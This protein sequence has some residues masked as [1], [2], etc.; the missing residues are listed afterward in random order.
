MV[1]PTKFSGDADKFPEFEN[2]WA[3]AALQMRSMQFSPVNRL[4]EPRKVLT[5][6]AL[7]YIAHLPVSQ[8]KSYIQ[9]LRILTAIYKDQKSALMTCV[10]KAL[11]VPSCSGS[12]AD[13]QKFH[14]ALIGYKQGTE[15]LGATPQEVLLAFELA[16]FEAK[17]DEAWRKDWLK[18]TSKRKD[19]SVPLGI[20][21]DFATF[22]S[23]LH[24]SLIEQMK[25]KAATDTA[26]NRR[27]NQNAKGAAN[28]AVAGRGKQGNKSQQ[29][30][31]PQQKQQGFPTAKGGAGRGGFKPTQ[32]Q[33]QGRNQGPQRRADNSAP[34]KKCPFC[35]QPDKSNKFPHRFPM[36]CPLV[37]GENKMSDE[38]IRRIIKGARACENCF[39]SHN[40][41]NCDAPRNIHCRKD[42]CKDRHHSAFH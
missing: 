33:G 16:V 20:R 12:V 40:T 35:V 39:D 25:I 6:T 26:L 22:V 29:K 17:L 32:G 3:K 1:V 21:V 23:K 2:L 9:A 7:E 30:G 8:D 36:Q 42:G 28:A 14:A 31:G 13:R 34:A 15:A 11:K 4:A 27:P 18:F 38:Q 24:L 10:R 5:G 37:T 19:T 41:A